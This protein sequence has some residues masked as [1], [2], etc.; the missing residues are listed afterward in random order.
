MAD[1]AVYERHMSS[2]LFTLILGLIIISGCSSKQHQA[3]IFVK[4]GIQNSQKGDLDEAEYDFDQAIGLDPQ[5][6]NAYY[7]R[8][9]VKAQLNNWDGAIADF[10]HAIQFKS[11]NAAA[12][13]C[14]GIAKQQNGDLKGA[15]ADY[16]QTITLD[17]QAA[18]AYLR[19]GM[20]KFLMDD[21]DGAIAD[22][23]RSVQLDPQNAIAYFHR[24]IAEHTQ[25]KLDSALADYTRALAIKPDYTNI[26]YAYVYERRGTL[27]IDQCDLD[28]AIADLDQAIELMPQDAGYHMDRGVANYL[29]HHPS[30]AITDLQKAAELR[31]I[32]YDYPRIF[33][34]LVKAEQA[35]QLAAANQ[36]LK[37]YFFARAGGTNDWPF[38][39][40]HFLTGGLPQPD[41]LEAAN[42]TDPKTDKEQHCEAYFYIATIYLLSGDTRAA[43]SFFQQCIATDVKTFYEYRMAKVKLKELDAEN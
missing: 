31:F 42:S 32:Y 19:R 23:T 4:Q 43:K 38:Q 17:P 27:K 7:H 39:V 35:D 28:G 9:V 41:F 13:F 21:W 2:R 30:A 26:F 36:E 3:E 40:G 34:W 15:L 25:G 14:R 11:Q 20:V 37:G 33:T 24:G 1:A 12:Y 18:H 16:T 22:Y 8:G 10:T 5:N 29:G 6:A